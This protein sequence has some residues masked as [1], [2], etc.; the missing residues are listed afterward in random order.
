[1]SRRI[2]LW[3]T[4]IPLALGIAV[5]GFVWRGYAAGFEADLR[6]VLPADVGV[7]AGGFPYRLEARLDSVKLDHRDAALEL[8]L[9]AE[10]AT[11]NR[12][13]WQRDRQ[14]ITVG[15][16]Q[17]RAA[18]APLTGAN[19]VL[20][21]P[22]ALASLRL[23]AERIARLS[24]VWQK[25]AI[26]TGLIAIPIRADSFEAHLRETPAGGT[27]G[28]KPAGP[29]LPT[30]AQLVLS[31]E[32]V[33]F[34]AGAPLKLALDSEMTGPGPIT[35]LAGWERG[36]TAEIRS[37]TLSDATGEVARLAGTLAA[38]G[39]RLRLAGTVETVCPATVRAAIA[40]EPAPREMRSRV[41]ERIAIGGTLPGGLTAAPRDPAKPPP[42]VRGQEPP[43]PA[44]R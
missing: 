42:P 1:M 14:V 33:R 5:W 22:E 30:Q 21:A 4:L 36:G 37:A 44:L 31:G 10:G 38:D 20:D 19:V 40:G 15:K 7:D 34:G 32:A 28:G 13:P 18:L 9:A 2:P 29:R 26:T 25:P 3:A 11:I 43:C 16:S 17:A 8:G 24:L 41:P 35:S 39:G 27:V 6:Q 12:V 23:D